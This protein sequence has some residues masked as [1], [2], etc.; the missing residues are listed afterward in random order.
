MAIENIIVHEV[1]K[2]EEQSVADTI[3]R[4]QENEVDS[5]AEDLSSHLSSLFRK[6]GLNTGQFTQPENEDDPAP[7]FVTLLSTYFIEGAFSDF[8]AFTKAA[9]RHFKRQIDSSGSSKGGYLWFNHY[10]HGEEHFLSVVLLRKKA[11]MTLNS[12]LT[13][14]E[15]EQLDLD[16]L[17]MAARINISAWLN[18]QSQRYI[19][20][21]IG[22]GARDVTDYFARFIGCEEYTRAKIDTQ[23]L[24]KVTAKY[25]TEHNL[26]EQQTEQAKQLVFDRCLAWLDDSQ[27]TKLDNLSTMLDSA[28]SIE[29]RHT[30]KFLEIAQNEPYCLTNEIPVERAAL[31]GLT[32]F[33]GRNKRI[34]LSFDSDL[35]NVS[36]FFNPSNDE[37]RITEPPE[38]LINQLK[39]EQ[40]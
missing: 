9:S 4:E 36:V 30:G 38:S 26:T 5:H 14:D 16:R 22:K 19:A 37:I 20:F 8:I 10:T 7:H 18:G 13:L 25:C 33:S 40:N 1:R 34:S 3:F 6:T 11:G 2:E 15:V 35:L 17:H 39:A 12:D 29:E 24:V 27:P 32:R 21:R 23:N 31:R 28:L